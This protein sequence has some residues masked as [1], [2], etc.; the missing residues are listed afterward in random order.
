MDRQTARSTAAT[1]NGRS[2]EYNPALDG[3]RAVGVALVFLHHMVTP[4]PFG[5]AIGVDIFFVLSGYL[6]TTVLLQEHQRLGY[7]NLRRFYLRRLV[8]LYPPLLVALSVVFLPGL[9]FAPAQIVFVF[10]NLLA[11]TYL[12]PFGRELG[13]SVSKAWG[14]T[15]TLGIE[16]AFYL[17]WPLLLVVLVRNLGA[18]RSVVSF[19]A[20]V[21]SAMM[22]SNV[23]IELNGHRPSEL[24]RAGGLFLGCAMALA[25]RRHSDAAVPPWVGWS[26]L[27]LVLAAV[28]HAP[29]E[30]QL[31]IAV[32]GAS[33]GSAALISHIATQHRSAGG[34]L[35]RILKLPPAVYLGRISYE[36]Y[37]WHY[38]VLVVIA[39]IADAE[40]V[41]VA[42]IAGPLSILLAALSHHML[43]PIIGNW[44]QRV[45]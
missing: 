21:S 2:I 35:F 43:A 41:Q 34:A 5:G 38:P 3:L 17:I 24:L 19:A 26:G 32:L 7:I 28:V 11:L 33:A 13:L 27:A 25:L 29:S 36:L 8:R 39:W 16:E 15:W 14:H 4:I 1:L 18:G 23:A 44:K 6:I 20:A 22:L 9:I 31:T 42:W 12:T 45:R 30:N 37:L 10:E 40:L